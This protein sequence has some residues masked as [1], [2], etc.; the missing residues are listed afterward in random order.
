MNIPIV[1]S[2]GEPCD[3]ISIQSI[4]NSTYARDGWYK[5]MVFGTYRFASI[6]A[7]GNNI[8][9]ANRSTDLFM[10]KDMENNWVVCIESL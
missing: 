6:D 4:A 10:H 9:Y 1:S 8:Y 7:R 2:I 5:R 3:K